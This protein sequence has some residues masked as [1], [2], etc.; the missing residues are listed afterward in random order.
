MTPHQ[1]ML[2]TVKDL[3]LRKQKREIDIQEEIS[4][5]FN[6]TNK[7]SSKGYRYRMGQR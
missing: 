5:R 7:S 3:K 2:Q 6:R 1:L 4:A